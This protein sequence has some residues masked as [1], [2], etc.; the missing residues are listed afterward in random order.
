MVLL[1]KN[2]LSKSLFPGN[3]DQ[4]AR[5]NPERETGRK[6]ETYHERE[7]PRTGK[8]FIVFYYLYLP[9]KKETSETGVQP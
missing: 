5:K 1:R 4:A 3:H 9:G 6:E 8:L 2:P 7:D